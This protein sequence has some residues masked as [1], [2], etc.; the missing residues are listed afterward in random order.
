MRESRERLMA[1]LRAFDAGGT[2][3][4]TEVRYKHRYGTLTPEDLRL[5]AKRYADMASA[6]DQAANNLETPASTGD[7]EAG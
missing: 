6:L 5:L 3:L 1:R 2:V 4:V 7:V